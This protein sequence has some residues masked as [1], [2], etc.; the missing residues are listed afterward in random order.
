[1]LILI[2]FYNKT[3]KGKSHNFKINFNQNQFYK[4]KFHSKYAHPNTY[5]VIFKAVFWPT[6]VEW[7]TNLFF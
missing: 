7:Y 2:L 6:L 4:I 3:S 1:M 5:L